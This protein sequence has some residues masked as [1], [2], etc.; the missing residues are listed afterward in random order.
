MTIAKAPIIS[1]RPQLAIDGGDPVVRKGHMMMARWPRLDRSDLE[2]VTRQLETGLYTEMAS[3]ARVREF[4]AEMSMMAGT[5]YALA[6]H[7]GTAALHCAIAGLGLQSGDEVIVPALA[8][9]ACAAAVI[10]HQAIPIFADVD[11]AT[12]NVTAES[13]EAA[14]T[15]RTRAIMVV[16]LHGLPCD[17]DAICEVGRRLGIPIIEDFSQAVGATYRNR[18]VGGLADV[19]AASLMAG[20]NLPSAGEAGVLVTNNRDIRNRAA[21]VKAFS[22]AVKPDGSYELIGAT[23]GW[24]YRI[25]LL[26]TVMVSRQLFHLEKYTQARQEGAARLDA[27]LSLIRGFTPPF[28]PQDRQHCYHMYRFKFDPEVAGLSVTLD[29][30]HE[31]LK[32]VFNAEGLFLVEFQNQP[33]PGHDLI[34]QRVG[35]GRGCPWRCHGREDIDYGIE[36]FPGALRAIRDSL[37][38]G[39]PSQAVLAN[40]EVVDAYVATIEKLAS[41][42]RIFERFAADLPST[43]PWSASARMF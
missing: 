2:A 18:P 6:V 27:S 36:R 15:P 20:K 4:E 42:M 41:N 34:R 28:V 32:R 11:P 37:V 43:T 31:A 14:I 13:V 40:P 38:I 25:N 19:G 12:Y 35:Y 23:M 16:H 7:S 33:L 22:E 26:S 24:N 39:M 17:I 3:T 29:Q 21:A 1:T 10:H 9:I 5:R 30:A 8:Y